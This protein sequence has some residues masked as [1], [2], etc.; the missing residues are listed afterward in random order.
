MERYETQ[1]IEEDQTSQRELAA[2][3]R[4]LSRPD[5]VKILS[6]A[7]T[8]ISNSTYAMEELNLTPKKYYYRLNELLGTDLITKRNGVYRQT[9]LGRI[10]YG[11]FLPAMGKTIDAKNELGI[12]DELEGTKLESEV[13]KRIEEE[14][15]IPVFENST[16]VKLLG[17]YESLAIEAIDLYDSAEESVLLAS[18]YIDVRVMEACF[19]SVDRGITNRLIVD[20][21]SLLS[22]IQSLRGMLSLTFTKTI[23]NFASSKVDLKEFLKFVDLPY[24]FCI[25]DG[26]HNII[27]LSNTLNNSFIV[28]L[29]IDDRGVSEKLTKFYEKLWKA[30]KTNAALNILDSIKSS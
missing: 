16:N 17:D 25:V 19:R 5:T 3:L 15:G 4:V 30:G 22:K 18:N 7:E 6:R 8:G 29:S 27:E 20:K 2:I 11:R 9:A 12:L 10:M 24:T 21:K 1:T 23:I 28:A 26:H 13:R 14:L